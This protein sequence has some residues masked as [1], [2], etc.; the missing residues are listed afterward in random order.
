MALEVFSQDAS[1]DPL[2]LTPYFDETTTI[3]KLACHR[4]VKQTIYFQMIAKAIN[5]REY[6]KE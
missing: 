4:N 2:S 6:T 3:Y 5:L 1:L